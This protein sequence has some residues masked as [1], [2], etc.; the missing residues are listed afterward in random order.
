MR[1][2][3]HYAW[4]IVFV[5]F[6]T[7]L[8]VQ[9]A[10][11]SFGAFVEPWE[12]DF[13]MNRGTI[14]LISTLSFIIYGISQPI[15]GRLVDKL[16]PRMILSVST[17][18]LGISFILTSFVNHPWQLFILYGIVISVG[19]GGASNVAATVVVTN[20]FNEKRG[21]AF[22]I[23]E[24]GFG[25]GQMLLVPGSLILIQWFNWKLTVVILGLIL[26]V[27]VFPV[28]LLLLRNHPGEMGLSPMGGFMKAEAESEQ[29]TAHFS[30]WT[31]F[32]KKQF[33]FLILPFAI[34]G[35]TTTGLMDTHLIPFSH[36]HGFSTSVTSAAVSVLAGF[37]IGDH[38]LR[39]C[40]R[41]LEQ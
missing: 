26:M 7:F 32:C 8:A 33:W 41:P 18:V 36:D 39:N 31:V 24:A 28:I 35:F 10:R 29:H 14:S 5:T 30:V 6:F 22:G 15:I 16:G 21:L 12:K 11:L 37:N 2:K 20:W 13:S 25:A 1:V 17:F 3:Y 9:G 40:G 38:Y 34:C 4:I 19:V 27:I 23:M